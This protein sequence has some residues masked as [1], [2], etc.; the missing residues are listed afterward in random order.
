[1]RTATAA[2]AD[3]VVLDQYLDSYKGVQP[4]FF[5]HGTTIAA[6]LRKR[7][8]DPEAIEPSDADDELQGSEVIRYR[9]LAARINY[10]SQDRVDVQFA[11]KEARRGMSKPNKKDHRKLKRLARYLIQ[12]PRLILGIQVQT[13]R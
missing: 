1:M 2:P 9:V 5:R 13:S 10:L 4:Q 6:E 12:H 3:I 7:G 11:A 8:L